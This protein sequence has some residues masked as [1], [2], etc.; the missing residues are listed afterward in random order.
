[1]T[2]AP[3]SDQYQVT[4]VKYGTRQTVRSDVYLNYHL[5]GEPDGPIGMDC[6]FWVVRNAHR[7]IVVTPGSRPPAAPTASAPR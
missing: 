4:I 2:V 1:M 3:G 5:Y 7:T 6:F